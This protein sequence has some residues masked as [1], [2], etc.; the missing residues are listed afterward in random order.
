MVAWDTWGLI[1]AIVIVIFILKRFGFFEYILKRLI[2]YLVNKVGLQSFET[3]LGTLTQT[4]KQDQL[5]M[6]VVNN[7]AAIPY[8]YQNKQSFVF[9]PYTKRFHP[10]YID[11]DVL[12]RENNKLTKITQQPGIS[13]LVNAKQL[14]GTEIILRGNDKEVVLDAQTIPTFAHMERLFTFSE[15]DVVAH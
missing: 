8:M 6:K 9:V 3:L 14:G 5:T 11:V 15:S 1:S 7:C 4:L 10:R 2:H 12:L 13:Y